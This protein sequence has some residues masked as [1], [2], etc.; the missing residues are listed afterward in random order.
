MGL[1]RTNMLLLAVLHSSS[2]IETGCESGTSNGNETSSESSG[3][4]SGEERD[5]EKFVRPSP[6]C[7]LSLPTKE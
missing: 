5:F 1:K 2:G 4:G 7:K 6:G 3:E